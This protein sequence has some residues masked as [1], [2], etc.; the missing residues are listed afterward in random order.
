MSNKHTYIC[1]MNGQTIQQYAVQTGTDIETLKQQCRRR[2]RVLGWP[3]QTYG[4][5]T[6]L[7][8][9]MIACLYADKTAKKQRGQ[10]KAD[11]AKQTRPNSDTAPTNVPDAKPI[12][13]RHEKGIKQAKPGNAR[14][15]ILYTLMAVP[16]IAS[17]NNMFTVTGHITE[18]LMASVLIT[19]LLSGAPFALVIAGIRNY[20]TGALVVLM[21]GFEVFCNTAQVYGGLTRFGLDGYPTRFLGL[22]TELLGTGTFI[23]ARV[24][25]FFMAAL[26]AS[27]FY[28]SYREIN[29]GAGA[30]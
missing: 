21:I 26:I 25:A 2:S 13:A 14:K 3:V 16:A 19:A 27:I 30:A 8:D 29:R 17:L 11:S 12:T 1:G 24:L 5:N 23:T 7:S 4:N 6:V 28:A 15:A 20:L 10:R 18:S 22:V 9:E